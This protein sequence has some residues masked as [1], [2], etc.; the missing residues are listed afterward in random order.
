MVHRLVDFAVKQ[1]EALDKLGR[2]NLSRVMPDGAIG[3]QG[4]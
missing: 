1:E 4:C 2:Y 3:T